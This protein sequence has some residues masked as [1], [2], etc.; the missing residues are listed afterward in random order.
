MLKTLK[1]VGIEGTY[2]NNI[3]AMYCRYKANIIQNKETF[4][5]FFLKSGTRWRCLLSPLLFNVVP[6]PPASAIM[7]EKQRNTDRKRSQTI[8]ADNMFIH[9]EEPK[10]STKK[11]CRAD[12]KFRK[13]TG[14]KTNTQISIAFMYSSNESVEKKKKTITL[15]ITLKKLGN[16]RR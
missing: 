3:K 4:K 8:S 7:Q 13:V 15:T 1:K 16:L 10:T 5:A 12:S 11:T 2:L 9:L 14:Y 6:E